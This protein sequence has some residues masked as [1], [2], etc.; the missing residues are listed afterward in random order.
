MFFVIFI[1]FIICFVKVFLVDKTRVRFNTFFK[2]GFKAVDGDYGVYCYVG[3]QGSFKTYNCINFLLDNRDLPI[4]TN[5]SS[6]NKKVIPYTYFKELYDIIDYIV[7]N[8]VTDCIV[9]L[10]EIFSY[11][12][13]NKKIDKKLLSFL[14]QLRK[15]RIIFITTAQE[16]LEINMTFRRYCRYMIKT[17]KINFITSSYLI[18]S[19]YDAEQ[20]QWSNEENDYI[21]PMISRSIEKANLYTANLYDTLEVI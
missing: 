17:K 4:Y 14:S 18:K 13:K 15:R 19:F 10:D 9:F 1:I 20:M 12:E 16:W 21:C 3:K 7:S 11:V 2:R 5:V 8:N 6:I